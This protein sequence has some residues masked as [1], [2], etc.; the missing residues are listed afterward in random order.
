VQIGEL[1]LG[2]KKET[3]AT[4]EPLIIFVG[5]LLREQLPISETAM[6]MAVD[7]DEAVASEEKGGCSPWNMLCDTHLLKKLVSDPL[8]AVHPTAVAHMFAPLLDESK[9][10]KDVCAARVTALLDNLLLLA[11]DGA[12][13]DYEDAVALYKRQK[14]RISERKEHSAMLSPT[15][16]DALDR[17]G[18]TSVYEDPVDAYTS[19]EYQWNADLQVPRMELPSRP[20]NVLWELCDYVSDQ[21][22]ES[23]DTV[24]KSDSI[25]HLIASTVCDVAMECCA[26]SS[27]IM[28]QIF[29]R[30][31]LMAVQ[32]QCY[33]GTSESITR[34]LLAPFAGAAAGA[35]AAGSPQQQQLLLRLLYHDHAYIRGSGVQIALTLVNDRSLLSRYMSVVAPAEEDGGNVSVGTA[36]DI[37]DL[38]AG[39]SGSGGEDDVDQMIGELTR[40][41]PPPPPDLASAAAA[42]AA[43][44]GADAQS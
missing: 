28:Q 9:W 7:D 20:M 35:S 10:G 29:G 14:G 32:R 41:S 27:S 42:A 24:A 11:A 31:L 40:K 15:L 23:F 33:R 43:N 30:S 1:N 26:S 12:V 34:V 13:N 6:S 16:R 5:D 4:L 2:A 19:N 39:D 36:S 22:G 18:V 38:T 17:V 44:A 37:V 8:L 21:A 3:F 25:A